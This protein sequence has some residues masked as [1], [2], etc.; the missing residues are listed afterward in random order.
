M[1]I[2]ALGY[3]MD[4]IQVAIEN[5]LNLQHWKLVSV[6]RKF[7]RATEYSTHGWVT[8]PRWSYLKKCW[9]WFVTKNSWIMSPELAR[10]WFKGWQIY[11]YVSHESDFWSFIECGVICHEPT[12][13]NLK[14]IFLPIAVYKCLQIMPYVI[15]VS[16]FFNSTLF[17]QDLI[18]L[19]SKT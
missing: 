3:L 19:L 8:H 2:F 6:V 1:N 14:I 15:Q 11:R 9:G 17:L 12:N 18:R 4:M 7:V 5:E 13:H 16:M 10:N